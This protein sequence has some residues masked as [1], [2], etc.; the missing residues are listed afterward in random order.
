MFTLEPIF[1]IAWCKTD[2]KPY[3]T[4]YLHYRAKNLLYDI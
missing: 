1:Y 4:R 2:K 3:T